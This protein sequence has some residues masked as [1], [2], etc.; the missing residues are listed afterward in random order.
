LSTPGQKD[1][2][3]DPAGAM[4]SRPGS[5]ETIL[6]GPC[7]P[8][9]SPPAVPLRPRRREAPQ[10]LSTS[11]L[12]VCRGQAQSTLELLSKFCG[13]MNR[14]S[15]KKSVKAGTRLGQQQLGRDGN[16][17]REMTG[18]RG[19][20]TKIKARGAP[21]WP[22]PRLVLRWGLFRNDDLARHPRVNDARV[23]ERLPRILIGEGDF[24]TRLTA[25][26][27]HPFRPE[28][29]AVPEWRPG[30]LRR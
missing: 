26:R 16:R 6:R 13:A 11:R 21:L 1:A 18:P 2:P 20:A 19:G 30:H 17:G 29:A 25:G 15:G 27:S 10:R 12:E 5:I 9:H 24:P 28:V 4:N 8:N 23:D 7:T 3:R 22:A 14:S